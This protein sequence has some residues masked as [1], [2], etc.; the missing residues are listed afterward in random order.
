MKYI[1]LPLMLLSSYLLLGQQK[2]IE[3]EYAAYF[4]LPRESLYLHL[5]K[6][7][8]LSGEEIWFK[9][10]TYDRKNHLSSKATTN[11][12]VGIYDA[13]G[14]QLKK[15]L[16]Q[17]ENGYTKGNF[18]IDSTFTSGIYYIKA[19][20]NWMKNFKEDDS[21]IQKIEIITLNNSKKKIPKTNTNYDF[22]FLPEGGHIVANT[23]NN[24]GLKVLDK[25][26]KGIKATGIIYD[27]SGTE[28]TTFKSNSLG[29]GKFLLTPSINKTYTS[30][31]TLANGETVTKVIPKIHTK[32]VS[33]IVN[34]LLEK[35]VIINFNTNTETSIQNKTYKLLIHQNGKLK[36]T[37]FTFEGIKDKA[38]ILAKEELYKGV[39]TITLFDEN[40]NPILERMFFNDYDI[41]NT[42]IAI[43]KINTIQ[44][45]II[46]SA[47]QFNTT[48]TTN[49]SISILPKTTEAYK[50]NHSIISTFYLK[51]FLKGVIENPQY[52]FNN[53]DKKKKYELDILLL[54]QGWS[55]YS[56]N[57]IFTNPPKQT[58]PFE[59][60]ITIRGTLNYPVKNIDS[61]FLHS[62]EFH[63]AQF[64]KLDKKKQF[65]IHNFYLKENEEIHF[66][67]LDEKGA[68]KKPKMYVSF[69]VSKVND[70]I[71][72]NN[73]I[74]IPTDKNTANTNFELTDDFFYNSSENLDAVVLQ[75]KKR[76]RDSTLRYG[77]VTK[78][79]KDDYYHYS[80]ITN[81][82]R[83]N[84]FSVYEDFGE[85]KI[86]VD[87]FSYTPI[88]PPLIFIDNVEIINANMLYN[89]PM[90]I[91]EKIT[92]DTTGASFG[93]RGFGGVI[94]IYTRTTP[95]FKTGNYSNPMYNTSVAPLAFKK[96]KDYYAPKYSAYINN[97]FEKY[98]GISWIPN[99][100]LINNEVKT[101]KILDTQTKE[102]TLFIEGI[103][104][105]GDL[106]S[107]RKTIQVR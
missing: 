47:K 13:N 25:N 14:N 57:D 87:R 29:L 86:L 17:A 34:S 58:H 99:L 43:S 24:I 28:I 65:S 74:D 27:D 66:S 104:K 41:K 44:D 20:T 10:Y 90:D 61:L 37:F 68:L 85:V 78:I 89:Y 35:I 72:T 67:Y 51:P 69:S 18:F 73:L 9:G 22:Q 12:N 81:F 75:T 5:N 3:D 76:E 106:I 94:K 36:T 21:Y 4:T 2:N 103:S 70:S 100:N 95:L 82:I 8:Y 33:V 107:E 93:I 71:N 42:S 102:V 83:A 1:L 15:G 98:G 53:I 91:I 7:T 11:I 31:I 97:T 26:G 50:P 48:E 96:A 56:W 39:N 40:D 77:I 52:Y 84:G 16:F 19:T 45:S 30:K 38:I 46:F 6:T 79:T 60:G 23:K 62:T 105:N 101:F 88:P 64:I 63:S 80:K 92:I 54:T 55:K 32:G 59:N 49:L